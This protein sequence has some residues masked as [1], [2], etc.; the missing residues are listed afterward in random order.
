MKFVHAADLHLDSPLCGLAKYDGAPADRIRGASRRA[1]ENLVELCVEE[2]AQLLLLAGDIFD[3]TW[4]DHGTGLFF[5]QQLSRLRQADVRVVWIR[6]NHDA[7]SEVRRH[8]HMPEGVKE[9]RVKSPETCVLEELG[10]AVHGQGFATKA[11]TERLAE[12]YPQRHTDLFNIGLLHTSATGRAG[13]EP[14]APCTVELLANK[15]YDYWALGHVHQREVLSE[16]P[17]IVFPGNLQGRHAR[18]AGSKGASIVTVES[19]RIQRVEH[20]ALDVVRWEVC[21]VD[22]TN[23]ADR[24][25]VLSRIS[26]RLRLAVA[27]ADD[28]LLAARIVITG[29]TLAHAALST[30]RRGLEESLRELA[31]DV[32]EGALWIEK[33]VVETSDVVSLGDVLLREDAV[34]QVARALR[35]LRDDED[36]L[37]ELASQFA[38]LSQKL[39]A[40]LLEGDERVVFD[41]SAMRD[42][43]GDVEQR[44]LTELLR[45]SGS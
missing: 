34:G 31:S 45:G 21:R 10:V 5:V 23:A 35:A 19:G 22:A 12:A 37:G 11:V 9:L 33:V 1:M 3:G 42:A 27:A 44:I 6:G 13:H 14:Y 29:E 7:A 16:D 20:R 2:E 41:V 40:E 36:A 17:W 24:D 8:L 43:I 18:E 15:G 28:R 39:P 38:E 30:S 26:E 32:G 4:K 25:D